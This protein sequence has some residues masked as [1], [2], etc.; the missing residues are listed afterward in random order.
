MSQAERTTDTSAHV[1]EESAIKQAWHSLGE[2]LH[3]REPT[4][5]P[6]PPKDDRWLVKTVNLAAPHEEEEEEPGFWDKF[7]QRITKSNAQPDASEESSSVSISVPA[8]AA[9]EQLGIS[10]DDDE[11][12]AKRNYFKRMAA[13][14]KEK[15]DEDN[16]KTEAVPPLPPSLPPPADPLEKESHGTEGSSEHH[17]GTRHLHRYL[18]ALHRHFHHHHDSDPQETQEKSHAPFVPKVDPKEMEA[19]HRRLYHCGRESTEESK[20]EG[21]KLFGSWWGWHKRTHEEKELDKQ[22]ESEWEKVDFP[23]SSEEKQQSMLEKNGGTTTGLFGSSNWTW[24][25]RNSS[26]ESLT[27]KERKAITKRH[28]AIASAAAYEAVKEY[29]ARKA[30][31]GKKVSHGEMKAMLAGMAMA[32]AIKLL[33]SNHD[34]DDDDDDKDETVAEAGSAALKLFE[35]LK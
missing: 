19:A 29:H 11:L 16:K 28:Q 9:I 14:C 32:E 17:R 8:D 25:K 33:E 34:D 15:F 20:A 12:Q 5:P 23:K 26:T 7:V 13:R 3:L 10:S 35:L 30:R 6:V 21:R 31:H 1:K 18:E 27:R 24:W 22:I 2:T 4:P